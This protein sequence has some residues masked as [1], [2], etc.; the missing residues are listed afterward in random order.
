MRAEWQSLG[1]LLF[2]AMMA[3]VALGV[4][5]DEDEVPP[6]RHRESRGVRIER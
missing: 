2:F 4:V 3:G 1:V 5:G 6:P